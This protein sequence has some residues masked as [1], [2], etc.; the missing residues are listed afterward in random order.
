MNKFFNIFTFIFSLLLVISCE[1][2]RAENGD[3]LFGVDGNGGNNGTG[4]TTTTKL[5]AKVTA[6]DDV[7]GGS[8]D[9]NYSYTG[10][11]LTGVTTSNNSFSE[12]ISYTGSNISKIVRIK[13]DNGQKLTITN[14]FMYTG[15]VL[16][17][18]DQKT[19]TGG[20]IAMRQTTTFTYDVAG[21]V[22]KAV[23]KITD[24]ETPPTLLFTI[25]SD[26]GFAGGNLSK[27]DFTLE[28]EPMPPI[29]IPPIILNSVLS[30]YD[31]AKSAYNTLPKS[32]CLYAVHED[33]DTMGI[34]GLSKNNVRTFNVSGEI[35][36]ISYQYDADNYPTSMTS[37]GQ[38]VKFEYKIP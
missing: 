16:S 2:G 12:V 35:Q 22:T 33:T 17:K 20:Q 29:T 32:Y 37:D 8:Y 5:L 4:G 38:T 3:L 9:I 10:N 14:D 13:D 6:P 24:A 21:N 19:E 30:N 23:T 36:Q 34:Y 31:S 15:I 26:F 1:P 11:Q 28:T 7:S 27:W 25:T 18:I